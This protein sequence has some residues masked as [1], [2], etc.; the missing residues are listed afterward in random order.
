[1]KVHSSDSMRTFF[2][3]AIIV[4]LFTSC[5]TQIKIHSHND[6]EQK[7]P[8]LEAYEFKAD[9]IEADVFLLG[10]SLVVA[11]SKKKINPKNT[12]TKLY[13]APIASFFEKYGNRVS[14]DKEC[15][16]SLMIDVKEN[17]DL[18]YPA[19]RKEIEK[20]GGIFDR[21]KNKLA[22]QIV[23]SGERPTDLTFHNYPKWLFF[24]G[25]PN[26]NYAEEDFDRVTMISD[27]FAN[28]SKWNGIGEMPIVDREKLKEAV[29]D[30]NKKHRSFRFWGA[31]DT[32]K[33]WQE[34]LDL[35]R[36]IINTDKISESKLSLTKNK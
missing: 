21:S 25:L 10:D 6:Y 7:R 33:C 8:F 20:Y 22:I 3:L 36:V 32:K 15:T 28:Y 14:I 27:N 5:S 11:H 4:T 16:F 23:I 35:G 19:L 34:L 30:A 17:W 12:L 9:E 1:M 29:T 2:S 26:V 13:L 18:I 31:P 24:D